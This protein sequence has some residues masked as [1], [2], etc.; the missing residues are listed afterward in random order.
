MRKVILLFAI[1]FLASCGESVNEGIIVGKTSSDAYIS[2]SLTCSAWGQNGCMAW[3]PITNYHPEQWYLELQ[4]CRGTDHPYTTRII[5]D[6]CKHGRISVDVATWGS[7]SEGS[8]YPV[9][10]GHR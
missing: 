5:Y 1:L 4:D 2:T 10:G 6:D 7:V 8:W 9:G 3:V